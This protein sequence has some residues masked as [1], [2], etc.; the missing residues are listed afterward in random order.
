MIELR[1]AISHIVQVH[2]KG[3]YFDFK[4]TAK[5][6]TFTTGGHFLQ[7]MINSTSNVLPSVGFGMGALIGVI[8][9]SPML[10]SK[11]AIYLNSLRSVGINIRPTATMIRLG[12][13]QAGDYA[14]S[15]GAMDETPEE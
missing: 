8:D 5:A 12:L 10:K 3:A 4:S 6:A 11:M 7:R 2:S 13:Y 14:K 15:S 9:A 1:E